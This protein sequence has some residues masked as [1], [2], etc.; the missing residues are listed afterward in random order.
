MS[1]CPESL[2]V[3]SFIVL[4]YFSRRTTQRSFLHLGIY[5]H[6]IGYRNIP[7]AN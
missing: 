6:L 4:F 2:L 5:E 3:V 7:S 1:I